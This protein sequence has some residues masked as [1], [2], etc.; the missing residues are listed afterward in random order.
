MRAVSIVAALAALL[1]A[2]RP[3]AVEKSGSAAKAA[4]LTKLLD[5]H[6]LDAIAA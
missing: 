5:Q 1:V 2:A 3:G 4:A 6:K